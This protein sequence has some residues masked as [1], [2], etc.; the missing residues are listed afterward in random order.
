MT[1]PHLYTTNKTHFRNDYIDIEL[2]LMCDRCAVGAVFK[3]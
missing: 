2:N 1:C 3:E